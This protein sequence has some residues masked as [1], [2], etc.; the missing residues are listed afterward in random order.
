[1]KIDNTENTICIEI[2]TQ[3]LKKYDIDIHS[4]LTICEYPLDSSL[5]TLID[6]E[7]SIDFSVFQIMSIYFRNNIWIIYLQAKNILNKKRTIKK[8][9]L[10]SMHKYTNQRIC[11]ERKNFINF[12]EYINKSIYSK[13][14]SIKNGIIFIKD[15][16]KEKYILNYLSEFE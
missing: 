16:S 10:T 13:Y 5:K 15:K 4:L 2:S 6:S 11:E 14:I 3:E 12:Y 9:S 8:Y 1:M 7:S